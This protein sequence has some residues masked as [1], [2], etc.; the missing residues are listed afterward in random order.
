[1]ALAPAGRSKP[2]IHRRH[3][4]VRT[5][6]FR[7]DATEP[8]SK[9]LSFELRREVHVLDR[10]VQAGVASAC[11]CRPRVTINHDM[12]IKMI[13]LPTLNFSS[14]QAADRSAANAARSRWVRPG[15]LILAVAVPLAVAACTG[16]AGLDIGPVDHSCHA[17]PVRGYDSGGS[18][19][20]GGGHGGGR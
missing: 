11:K 12:E 9:S 14:A 6:H 18:G 13:A 8:I 1:M 4:D 16:G 7:H 19:C 15:I 5:M 20:S 2:A 17:N 10:K 3:L